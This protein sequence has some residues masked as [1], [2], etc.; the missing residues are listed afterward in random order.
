LRENCPKRSFRLTC[1]P[2]ETVLVEDLLRSQGYEFED[3]PFASWARRSTVEPKSLGAS[4]AAF[5]GLIY[6]QDR[7]SMLPPLG[8]EAGL[9]A[10]GGGLR[11]RAALDMCASP[12][13]KSGL[14]A[15]FVGPRGFV[16]ANEPN[17]ER[18]ATLRQNLF[19]TH[20]RNVGVCRYDGERLPLADESWSAI[21][22]DPPCS[23]WGT[24]EKNP[25]VLRLWRGDKVEPLIKLQRALL[26]KAE[27]LLAP[28]GVLLYSTC[29]TNEQEN[30][31]QVLWALSELGFELLP[32]P[33]FPGFVFS[34]VSA[35][36][37]E[38]ALRV[39]A[40]SS[41]AQ[42]FFLACLTKPG[43]LPPPDAVPE[44]SDPKRL[45]P[46]RDF[47]NARA[48]DWSGWRFGALRAFNDALVYL[49]NLSRS[50][51]ETATGWQGYVLGKIKGGEARPHCRVRGLIPPILL[52]RAIPLESNAPG[53][54]QPAP[55]LLDRLAGALSTADPGAIQ[56]LLSGQSLQLPAAVASALPDHVGLFYKSLPLCWLRVKGSRLLW[57]ER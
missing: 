43:Q 3:E 49:P 52:E 8:L 33:S 27:R 57:A 24:V 14:L 2:A 34:P 48:L 30:E 36:A 25:N 21:L 26:V 45:D 6:I 54:T 15:Q 18:Y 23:G 51:L 19:R 44:G 20:C 47:D 50:K 22:L 38:G 46:E 35:P 29:T 1:E 13:G 53:S 41:R 12:G 7:S 32:L 16:L 31:E 10:K 11:D 5:F 42:G 55:W 40:A 9:Q 4:L 37:A 56:A 17:S 28:G 39:D